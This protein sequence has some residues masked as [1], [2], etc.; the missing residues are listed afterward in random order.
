MSVVVVFIV[1]VIVA[2]IVAIS[3][4]DPSASFDGT[5]VSVVAHHTEVRI[6]DVQYRALVPQVG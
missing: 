2:I 5:H 3:A 1:T 4:E 6:P